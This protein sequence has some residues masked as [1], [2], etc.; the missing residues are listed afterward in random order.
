MKGTVMTS[1][2]KGLRMASIL[3]TDSSLMACRKGA[4]KWGRGRETFGWSRY[5]T[6]YFS[7]VMSAK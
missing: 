4:S 5:D 7:C 3:C 6:V 1:S 2:L